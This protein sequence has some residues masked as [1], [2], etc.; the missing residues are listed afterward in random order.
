MSALQWGR[1]YSTAEICR[2]TGFRHQIRASMGPRLFNRG[3]TFLLAF[4]QR[5][6]LLQWG[7]GYS[8]AEMARSLSIPL[9]KTSRS[10]NERPD[11][12]A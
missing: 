1:S 11:P 10:K 7:R 2:P 8:T 12:N 6:Y 5:L 3:N 4:A 9:S